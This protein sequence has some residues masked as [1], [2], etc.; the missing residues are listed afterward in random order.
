MSEKNS[1]L[2]VDDEAMNITALSHILKN[3]YTIYVEKDGIGC[4]EAA[5]EL[6]PDLIL[7]DVLMPAMSGFEVINE[8][9]KD[10]T[11]HDIPV[12]FV[13]GLNNA[14]DE[15]M[16]FLRGAADY[17][18]KPFSSAVVKLRVHNHM[19]II[20]QMRLIHQISITDA[21]T[22][23][24]N[25]RFFYSQMEHEWQR[26]L[27]QQ[28]PL[29]FMMLDIDNFKEYN[30]KNGH[31][32]GDA[33]LKNVAEIIKSSLTRA[34]DIVARWGGEEFVVILPDTPL[35]GTKAVAE[36]IRESVEKS[37]L[38]VSIG[39]NCTIPMKENCTQENFVSDTDKALYQAKSE[40]R[41]RVVCH[42]G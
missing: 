17:I 9:K 42:R 27:R 13:T 25:R 22:G 38:T 6:K 26:S 23:I 29:G 10:E 7:L 24:G 37:G 40:G 5:K 19:K 14:Q 31:L 12:I 11:T 32:Q 2:I 20:N 33:V 8:L 41:N 16:G 36:R 35:E 21:L 4:I 15:E 18:N 30:D 3:D 28:T 34:I 1:V 39:V